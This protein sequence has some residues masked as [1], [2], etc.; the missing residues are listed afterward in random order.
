MIPIFD[1]VR[2]SHRPVAVWALL[3]LNLA[4]FGLQFILSHA[5]QLALLFHWALVPRRYFDWTWARAH[6][7]N[8]FEL[9]PFVTNTF[10]HGG[11]WHIA[12]NLWMLWIFGRALEDRLGSL[13]FVALYLIAGIVASVVHAVFNPASVVP[14][15]GASGAVAGL[16][17]AYALRF[18]YAWVTIVVPI[19]FVPLVFPVPVMAFAVVWF[20]MQILEMFTGFLQPAIG[21]GIAWWAHI[22]GFVAGWVLIGPLDKSVGRAHATL[23]WQAR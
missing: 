12:V 3:G 7:L 16:I 9:W 18:P 1:S 6:G 19:W 17:A 10:L 8:P 4:A 13:P 23:P 21:G 20:S 2:Y 5:Q 11:V 22:G 15:L 14:V